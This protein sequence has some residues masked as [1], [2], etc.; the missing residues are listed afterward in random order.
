VL[1]ELARQDGRR[2]DDEP[3]SRWAM[4]KIVAGYVD[5]TSGGRSSPPTRRN[6]R[7]G[8]ATGARGA[9]RPDPRTLLSGPGGFNVERDGGSNP[10]LPAVPSTHV[11]PLV[12]LG[13]RR[14]GRGRRRGHHPASSTRESATFAGRRRACSG[15]P[16][17]SWPRDESRRV[18]L[19][20]PAGHQGT[21]SGTAAGGQPRPAWTAWDGDIHFAFGDRGPKEHRRVSRLTHQAGR[22]RRP[23]RSR[24]PP[25]GSS[26][27]PF[28]GGVQG[29]SRRWR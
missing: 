21:R 26:R 20:C 5:Q 9:R 3:P 13:G 1:R 8:C 28:G 6:G 23:R 7:T 4:T 25:A 2:P 24:L 15:D 27:A 18:G 17:S 29:G 22:V 11:G 12:C 14:D 10:G 16:R 19:A